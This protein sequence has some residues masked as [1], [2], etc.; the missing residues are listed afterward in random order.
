MNKACSLPHVLLYLAVFLTG[1]YVSGLNAGELTQ[2]IN[3]GRD[4][5]YMITIY[6]TFFTC[7]GT[8]KHITVAAA[9]TQ[10]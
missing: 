2:H 6:G 7:S 9:F 1:R 4:D 8:E 10:A 3:P 5:G